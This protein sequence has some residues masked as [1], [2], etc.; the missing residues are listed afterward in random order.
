MIETGA[1]KTLINKIRKRQ[2]S[3]VGHFLRREG[4]ENIVTTGKI[5]GRR[6]RGR[7]RM[8]HLDGLCKW[9]SRSSTTEMI[10]DTRNRE[11][12]RSMIAY[13]ARLGT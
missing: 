5:P 4:L 9:L 11:K 13:A 7:Q 3:S 1:E 12:R 6:D 2:A 10:E 8:K